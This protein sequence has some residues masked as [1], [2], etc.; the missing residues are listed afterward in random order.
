MKIRT[1]H[2]FMF[3]AFLG[4][5]LMVALRSRERESAIH[6]GESHSTDSIHLSAVNR[7]ATRV[8]GSDYRT[9]EITGAELSSVVNT[10]ARERRRY[11]WRALDEVSQPVNLTT[12]DGSR[13]MSVPLWYTWFDVKDFI[14]IFEDFDRRVLNESARGIKTLP[15][16]R[17]DELADLA[18]IAYT[19]TYKAQLIERY[20]ASAKAL[21][22]ETRRF[23]GVTPEERGS[24]RPLNATFFSPSLLKHYLVNAE[25]L[26]N[27]RNS[28]VGPR[29]IASNLQPPQRPRDSANV[30]ALCFDSEFPRDAV[31][32]K[33]SWS[34]GKGKVPVYDTSFKSMV[35]MWVDARTT[36]GMYFDAGEREI[37]D[38][39]TFAIRTSDEQ[40]WDLIG[41]HV[42]TKEVDE[43][44]WAS[45]WWSPTPNEDFGSDRPAG[46]A[47][48]FP[49]FSNFKM[50]AQSG[51]DEGDQRPSE[52]WKGER[53]EKTLGY[54][55]DLIKSE[56]GGHQWCANP[57]FETT[58]TRSS[59]AHCH[60]QAGQVGL[61][62]FTIGFEKTRS[63]SLGD[64]L[65]TV[66]TFRYVVGGQPN[67]D[68]RPDY[69]DAPAG[70]QDRPRNLNR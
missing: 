37:H 1:W 40:Y 43:W 15:Q 14:L 3:A 11:A 8:V 29:E 59:C 10:N 4:A 16:T 49:A 22:E 51:F 55:L 27:C 57:Y 19:A 12:S 35:K 36:R 62:S 41:L 58:F 32:V 28:K 44:I 7:P 66:N 5:A 53:N 65:L 70:S 25:R 47:S 24:L 50:C 60:L 67:D 2:F 23:R 38:H 17:I 6:K 33:A 56:T 42:T 61:D 31:A 48:A 69:H 68:P 20:S 26:R 54:I 34:Y 9:A 64:F 46:L 30:W 21:P 13:S 52:S 39:E 45:F 63:N 18:M